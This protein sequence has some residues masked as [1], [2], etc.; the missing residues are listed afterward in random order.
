MGNAPPPIVVMGVQGSGKSTI[1]SLLA[2]RL[3][4]TF[5]DGDSLH[6]AEN[7]AAMAAGRALTDEQ[8]IPWLHEVGRTLAEGRASGIV[9][10]CSALK[11]SYRDL[12]RE[13]V[14][15]LFIVYPD[16]SMELIAARIGARKHEYMPPEL[17]QSQFDTLEPLTP[18]ER[19]VVVDIVK[20][21]AELIDIIVAALGAGPNAGGAFDAD[22]QS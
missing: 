2:D 21:P 8:R 22:Y 19:G 5:I 9:V 4:L 12:L 13:S 11:Q 1:G 18:G 17:L 14:S 3:G 10:A 15:D 16:G 6:T 7:V 20:P